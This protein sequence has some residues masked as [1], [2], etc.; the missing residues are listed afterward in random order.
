MLDLHHYDTDTIDD[1]KEPNL[2]KFANFFVDLNSIVGM[3]KTYITA[4]SGCV[5]ESFNLNAIGGFIFP[6]GKVF[7][8]KNARFSDGVDLVCDTTYRTTDTGQSS[9]AAA[10]AAEKTA[11]QGY[12]EVQDLVLSHSS[13]LMDNYLQGEIV[14][15]TGKFEA[16]QAADGHALVVSTSTSGVL[17]VLEERSGE[18]NAGWKVSDLSTKAVQDATV[19]TF[20]VGQNGLDGTIGLAMAVS[21]NGSDNLYVSLF[22]SSSD[23]SW[24]S[25]PQWSSYPFDAI[26]RPAPASLQI[27]G[28]LFAETGDKKQY[29]IVDIDRSSTSVVKEIERYYIDPSKST[30]SYWNKH[31]VPVDIERNVYQ[32]CVGRKRAGRVDGVYTTGSVDGSP[33]LIYTPVINVFGSGPP[34]PT[35]LKLPRQGLPSAIATAR[36]VDKSS[37]LWGT[38]DLYAISAQTLYRFPADGQTEGAQG[39]GVV[40]NP[41]LQGTETLIASRLDGVTTVWGKNSSNE[42]WYTSCADTQLSIPGAWSAPVPLL[43]GVEHICAFVNKE[44]KGN[45]I[46]TSG[47]GKLRR[48]L[49]STDTSAKIWRAH[50]IRLENERT[51]RPAAVQFKSYTTTI[52]VVNAANN[53]QPA[54]KA[55]V[56]IAAN[57]CTSFY[58]NGLYYLVGPTPTRV[59]TDDVGSLTIIETTDDLNSTPLTVWL[60]G[61]QTFISPMDKTFEKLATLNSGSSLRSAE[62]PTQIKAGGVQGSTDNKPLVAPSTSDDDVNMAANS[63]NKLKS[64]YSDAGESSITRGKC[65]VPSCLAAS[66]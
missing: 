31:D 36:N 60:A 55:E 44:D 48:L 33:Q 13:D 25:N 23:T 59:F 43:T 34:L 11:S 26:S 7:T 2:G 15:P 65:A 57:S 17:Q 46:F 41:F 12:S 58:I 38:T 21:R 35:S 10:A 66:H 49:Q 20:D 64:A 30:G 28:I 5:F 54:S 27:A 3:A 16:L 22:N 37:S 8:F 24:I 1:S 53:S 14:S 47:G 19:R 61:N 39:A 4:Y 9:T 18:N 52:Q 63:M 40:T 62:I 32:S 45:T 51:T 56:Q 6:G 29:L 50:D 42:V